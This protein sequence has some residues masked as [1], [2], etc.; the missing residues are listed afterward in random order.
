MQPSL[1][2][3]VQS[4]PMLPDEVEVV[5]SK[6]KHNLE[7]MGRWSEVLGGGHPLPCMRT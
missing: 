1:V 2:A 3:D 6:L 5:V 7:M 4:R